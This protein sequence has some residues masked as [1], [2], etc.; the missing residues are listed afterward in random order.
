MQQFMRFT[1]ILLFLTL[2]TGLWAQQE[3]GLHFMRETWQSS[4][5]NPAFITEHKIHVGLP[6]AY[7]NVSHSGP[8]YND[9]VRTDSEGNEVI[10][11]SILL[12]NLETNNMLLSH[13]ELETASVSFG[14]K[15][16]RFS[17]NHAIKLHSF[18]DY[19]KNLIELGWE[20][21][22]QFIGET[23]AFGPD[24]EVAAYNEFGIGAAAKLWG[25]SAGARLKILTGFAGA[26][27]DL[28]DASIYT[29]S[30]VYDITFNTDYRINTSS[31]L[32]YNGEGDFNLDFGELTASRLFSKNLGL[33]LDLGASFKVKKLE[34]SASII[35]LGFIKWTEN[36]HN[37]HSKGSFD[38]E[39]LDIDDIINDENDEI[40]FEET[41]DTLQNILDF[42]ETNNSYNT[43]LPTKIYLSA[44]Y[45]LNS[46][47]SLGGLFYSEVYRGKV[48]PAVAANVNFHIGQ[49]L[50][51]GAVY[52]VRNQTYDNIGLNLST[53]LG[54]VQL[55][56]MT[57]NI[58]A[59]F[60]PYSSHNANARVGLNLA[61]R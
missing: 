50:S 44:S 10:D 49:I 36:V 26:N 48:F 56:A 53:K 4:K 42:K 25:I 14:I 58:V 40:S 43:T 37:Y 55:F 60:D 1:T 6:S 27:S 39:G 20:G 35:D 54:P 28:T 12:D 41:I 11:M 13:F 8:A 33:A 9:V 18:L 15:N 21:N 51:V 31:F 17:I 7:F 24:F 32:V 19:P 52:A 38:F 61:F 30:D 2:S 22:E 59:A 57:D 47:W 34:V 5:T 23:V 46:T 16:V 29:D 45:D 3:L